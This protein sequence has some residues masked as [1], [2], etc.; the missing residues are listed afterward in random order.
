[1]IA[2][3]ADDLTG[4]AELGGIGLRYNLRVEICT[5]V[6]AQTVADLLIISTD[7]RSKPKEAAEKET[8]Q[9][10]RALLPLKPELIYKKMDSVLRGHVLPEIKAQMRA[11]NLQRALLV[12]ANPALGRTITNGIYYLQGIPIHQSSFSQD[13]EFPLTSSQVDSILQFGNE[14]VKVQS[15]N[16]PLPESGIIVGEVSSA[17]DLK[18]WVQS[19]DNE[20]ALAGASGF[21]TALLEAKGYVAIE[22]TTNLSF[23][24]EKPALFVC[25][26]TFAKSR[27]LVKAV[28]ARG[29][30]V[31][32]LPQELLIEPNISEEQVKK[33][34][35]EIISL[36]QQHNRAILAIA[37]DT[38][39]KIP[40]NAATLR[41]IMGQAVQEVFKQIGLAELYLEGGSTAAAIFKRLG[42]YRFYP[43]QE[44]APGVI[45][46][47]VADLPN[48]H[49][50]LK[51]GSY[52][53]PPTVWNFK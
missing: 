11:L 6:N 24:P 7:S 39:A 4:A 44:L 9:V 36:I 13:P 27:A 40:V 37:P 32:Y 33:W 10:I 49:L 26:S 2:V 29:G 30:P 53:W 25:G 12:P 5:Q 43:Q 34:V 16:Q 20:T 19:L 45:R 15:H 8:E 35:E 1:M 51:P 18:A 38:T 28:Q 23:N 48:L 31:S 46:M 3:V 47:Q 52:D 41:E 14:V 42:F 17:N 22:P 21:F 50:T